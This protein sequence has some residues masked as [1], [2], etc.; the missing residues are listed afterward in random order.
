MAM[1][2]RLT[3]ALP[4]WKVMITSTHLV[5]RVSL[6]ILNTDRS[7]TTI[8]SILTSVMLMAI[9][10]SAGMSLTGLVDGLLSKLWFP[11]VLR[12]ALGPSGYLC[13]IVAGFMPYSCTNFLSFDI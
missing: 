5:V 7:F 2:A 1:I 13:I 11:Y 9:S 3:A 4:F 10:S 6:T 8:T 12:P